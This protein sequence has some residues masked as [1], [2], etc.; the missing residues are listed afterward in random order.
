MS[1]DVKRSRDYD[2]RRRREQ[3]E[4]TRLAILEAAQRSLLE[5]GYVATSLAQIAREVGVAQDTVYKAFRN[6]PTLLK[7]VYD[8]AVAGDAAPVPILERERAARLRAEPDPRRKLEIYVAGLI[9]TLTRSGQLL[10]VIRGVADT[11]PEVAAIWAAIRHERLIGMTHLADHLAGQHH[12]AAHVSAAEARDVL[13]TYNSPELYQLLVL[14][15]GWGSNRY[16][17]WITDALAHALLDP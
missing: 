13:W 6:K 9:G 14:Q 12:L 16:G 8:L 15:R 5:R 11:D 17:A 1:N 4:R 10:L 7:A 3:A 2:N